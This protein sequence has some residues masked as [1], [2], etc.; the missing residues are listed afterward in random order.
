MEGRKSNC[1]FPCAR[2]F[3][4]KSENFKELMIEYKGVDGLSMK[5]F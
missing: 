5:T 1:T 4:W 3:C 2:F